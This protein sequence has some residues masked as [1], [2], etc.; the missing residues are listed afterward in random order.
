MIVFDN[1]PQLKLVRTVLRRSTMEQSIEEKFS[2]FSQK[3][4]FENSLWPL[5]S[6]RGF[7]ND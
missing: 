4:S 1:A 5:P 6:A 2:F 7:M 3:E